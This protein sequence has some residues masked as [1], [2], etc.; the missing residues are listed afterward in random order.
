[1]DAEPT[2]VD[3]TLL[4][5]YGE[6]TTITSD[7]ND[8]PA[9]KSRHLVINTQTLGSGDSHEMYLSDSSSSDASWHSDYLD[10]NNDGEADTTTA[11]KWSED[12]SV[13]EHI[14]LTIAPTGYITFY[15]NGACVRCVPFSSTSADAGEF[16]GLLA[17]T[18][19]F[20]L[21]QRHVPFLDAN[22]DYFGTI[23]SDCGSDKYES[24]GTAS[25]AVAD[26]QGKLF[27]FPFA[28][29]TARLSK[30]DALLVVDSRALKLSVHLHAVKRHHRRPCQ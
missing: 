11:T 14:T 17:D 26:L 8:P 15:K 1:M 18:T 23:G 28:F 22:I 6:R 9:E 7:D 10:V 12:G 29:P 2:D 13:W 19:D 25:G 24:S 16:S 30:T 3:R 4:C 20:A 27:V 5:F 21:D